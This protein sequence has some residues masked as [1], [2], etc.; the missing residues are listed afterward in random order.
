MMRDMKLIY[1]AFINV[2]LMVIFLIS[3]AYSTERIVIA[4]FFNN[5]TCANCPDARQAL[6]QLVQNYD[7]NFVSIRYHVWWADPDDP[8]WL[9]N[10]SE[11]QARNNYYNNVY[12]PHCFFDGTIDGMHTYWNW[13]III[14]G[15]ILV[16][17]PL[18]IKYFATFDSVSLTGDLYIYVIAVSNISQTDL[19]LRIAI[20]ENNLVYGDET[21]N[22]VFRDMIPDTSGIPFIITQGD[23]VE[24]FE[25]YSC[26]ES[27]IYQ[28]CE[29]VL[30]VQ[31][32]IDKEILQSNR[33]RIP[34]DLVICNY[35]VGDANGSGG[36]NGLDIVYSVNYFKSIGP[37]PQYECE[38]PPH[39]TWYV[40][41]DVNG[42]CSFNGLD[43]TYGVSYLKGEQT[44]LKPCPLCPPID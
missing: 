21:F 10:Q 2:C 5:I 34:E 18:D 43:I 36:Y 23:T 9:Y 31:S 42:S 35:V 32:D 29:I 7:S 37:P 11:I 26:P 44:E 39:G 14:Q 41:G 3:A 12:T 19:R 27:L 1:G 20:T 38:C 24:F 15:Q 40:S 17:S 30:F 28:N 4:E 13:E 6:D 25:Q 16:D 33:I 8:F 22:Q